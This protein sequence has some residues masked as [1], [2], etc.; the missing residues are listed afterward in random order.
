MQDRKPWTLITLI[1][2]IFIIAIVTFISNVTTAITVNTI[3]SNRSDIIA[4]TASEAQHNVY[5][6]FKTWLWCKDV[7]LMV[8]LVVAMLTIYIYGQGYKLT[9]MYN[10]CIGYSIFGIWIVCPLISLM[11]LMIALLAYLNKLATAGNNVIY[12]NAIFNALLLI[13]TCIIIYAEID[14]P[15]IYQLENDELMLQL[16]V[17]DNS[18]HSVT[19][20]I[21]EIGRC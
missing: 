1:V 13:V 20:E 7:L 8:I 18:S 2:I 10:R 6:S 17:Y 15:R 12:I 4:S 5:N 11:L 19:I 21:K 3:N 9:K 16:P 14:N